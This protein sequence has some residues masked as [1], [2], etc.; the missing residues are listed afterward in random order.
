MSMKSTAAPVIVI[1]A[2]IL[3]AFHLGGGLAHAG[4]GLYAIALTAVAML[5]MTGI[6]VAI[7]SY[8]PSPTTPAASPRCRNCRKRFGHH[9]SS[10]CGGN[11][12]KAVT[13]GYAIGSAGLAAL[14]LFAEFSR[15]FPG[16]DL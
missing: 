14:V 9:R 5:S 12:T 13:K 6:V 4:T 1:V 2:A 3:A 11:T 16:H 8:G 10:G 7:D 15:S